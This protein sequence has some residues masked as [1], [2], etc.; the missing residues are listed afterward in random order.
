MM[1]LDRKSLPETT[2]GAS[3]RQLKVLLVGGEQAEIVELQA[4]LARVPGTSVDS[5]PTL[6]R[7]SIVLQKG[8]AKPDL[9]LVDLNPDNPDDLALL[10]DLK[11]VTGISDVPVIALMDRKA[12]HAPL[13][14][15]RAGA[16]DVLFKPVDTNEVREVFSRVM[17]M[18]KTQ[19]P[20]H[21]EA[22]GKTIAF[23]HLSGGV[24]ATTLAVN[25]ACALARA[26]EGKQTCL[27]DL[28]IQFGNAASLLDLPSAS[29]TQEFIDDPSRLDEAMLE[30]MMLRHQT[31]LQVLT[32]PR[33]L[34][35]LTAY[36]ADGI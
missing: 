27:L 11:K 5:V 12:V 16:N 32:A 24:G 25:A 30:S 36:G 13:R 18:H 19:R 10:R 2:A 28:D 17:D 31:G 4:A 34:L 15:I 8:G 29:P 9:I 26:V 20:S 1:N 6:A 35:P 7:F 33:S 3:S 14:A 21:A 23:M 22:T